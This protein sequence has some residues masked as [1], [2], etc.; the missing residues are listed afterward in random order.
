MVYRSSL[1]CLPAFSFVS[2]FAMHGEGR[3]TTCRK[4]RGSFFYFAKKR[5]AV[6]DRR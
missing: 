6:M 5:M 1:L 4:R 3:Q 2:Y